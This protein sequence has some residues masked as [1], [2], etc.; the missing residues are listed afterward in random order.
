MQTQIAANPNILPL[1]EIEDGTELIAVVR[2]FAVSTGFIDILGFD[3]QGE[4]YVVETKLVR[5][6]DRRTV[7]AQAL[8]YGASLWA[9][10]A[11]MDQ[12]IAEVNAL[13][14]RNGESNLRDA[15]MAAHGGDEAAADTSIER[16]G[17]NMTNGAFRF[18]IPMDRIP[19]ELK[20]LTRYLNQ[21]SRFALYLVELEQYQHDELTVV[22]PRL[23]GAETRKTVASGTSGTRRSSNATEFQDDLRDRVARG[24]LDS[25][26]ASGI[27]RLLQLIVSRGESYLWNKGTGGRVSVSPRFPS[28]GASRSP[29]TLMSD[30]RLDLNFGYLADVPSWSDWVSAVQSMFAL[31]GDS[32]RFP[33]LK[34]SVWTTQ[35]ERLV[36]LTEAVLSVAK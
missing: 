13:R 7:V 5:N 32:R 18:V 20:D 24:E 16:I 2:E 25:T 8:D 22:V 28:T 29:F 34:P 12:F 23:F 35:A 3:A 15:L 27:E 10:S 4:I 19:E 21:N 14:A 11:D 6:P 31:T 33:Q 26:T 30:G 36:N 1:H 9:G 17:R